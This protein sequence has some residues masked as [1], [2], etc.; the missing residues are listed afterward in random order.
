MGMGDDAGRAG[1]GMPASSWKPVPAARTHCAD[2][3]SLHPP[4]PSDHPDSWRSS[5]RWMPTR[6]RGCCAAAPASCWWW[7]TRCAAAAL[8]QP[9]TGAATRNAP[10]PVAKDAAAGRCTRRGSSAGASSH[11]PTHATASA[12]AS[13]R[14]AGSRKPDL[15]I[16]DAVVEAL[17]ENADRISQLVLVT[18]ASGG[19]GGGLF[20]GGGGG[21]MSNV[22][23]AVVES[24]VEYLIVR[25]APSDRVTDRYGEQAATL[26]GPA[27]TLPS[28][29]QASRSQVR[30]R[31]WGWL[32]L[33]ACCMQDVM[34]AGGAAAG[35][36]RDQHSLRRRC[37]KRARRAACPAICCP[38]RLHLP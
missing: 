12:H 24:G 31:G 19:G 4:T 27:G 32:G 2:I 14:Q 35:P 23:R 18:P 29:L 6:L 11:P 13:N 1:R 17:L 10:A 20:K 21:R 22:E 5:T 37:S 28:G 34:A 33:A 26:V 3:Q 16:Y 8:G 36:Q 9:C 7:E 30:R 38:P 25:A 15:R